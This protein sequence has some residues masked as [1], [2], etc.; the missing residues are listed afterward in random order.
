MS[1]QFSTIAQTIAVP[2]SRLPE[3]PTALA[4]YGSALPLRP[5]DPASPST[6]TLLGHIDREGSPDLRAGALELDESGNLLPGSSVSWTELTDGRLAFSGHWS[7]A[8]LAA[9]GVDSRLDGI[10]ILTPEQLSALTPT[11]EGEAPPEP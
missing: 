6:V 11:P 3:L 2:P 8:F 9:F 5:A 10:S 1:A 4:E 7:S